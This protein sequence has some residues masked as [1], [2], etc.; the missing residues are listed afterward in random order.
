MD[1]D[2]GRFTG[3]PADPRT[4]DADEGL[5]SLQPLGDARLNVEYDISP[6]GLVVLVGAWINGEF[7]HEH[8]FAQWRRSAWIAAITT[9]LERDRADERDLEPELAL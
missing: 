8:E 2:Y 4:D 7:V 6:L 3:H 5:L 9:E 1:A